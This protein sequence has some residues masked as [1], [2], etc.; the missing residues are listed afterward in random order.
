MFADDICV[1]GP[2]ITALQ[3]L[4]KI[5]GDCSAE[6][7]IAFFCIETIGVLFRPKDYKEPDP[8][9]VFLNGVRVQ[10]SD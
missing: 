8:S 3:C 6:H 1:F 7:E 5:C 10:F 4:L 9:N 2:G